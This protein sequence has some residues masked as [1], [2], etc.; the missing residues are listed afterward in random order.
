M[1]ALFV[2]NQQFQLTEPSKPSR[3]GETIER[4]SS[5][6]EGKLCLRGFEAEPKRPMKDL[7]VRTSKG[8]ARVLAQH[9]CIIGS[10][11]VPER[12]VG[13]PQRE[14]LISGA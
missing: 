6:Y 7:P 3:E 2:R 9:S 11:N 14:P 1:I 4:F 5:L 10:L 8:G 12:I 13:A